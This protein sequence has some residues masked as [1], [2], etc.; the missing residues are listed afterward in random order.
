MWT[1]EGKCDWGENEVEE[2]PVVYAPHWHPTH[3]STY[4][5]AEGLYMQ[6]KVLPTTALLTEIIPEIN[7]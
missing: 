7:T 5:G 1:R 2:E 3:L 4:A 6:S